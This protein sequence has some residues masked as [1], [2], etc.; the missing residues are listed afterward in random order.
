MDCPNCQEPL[1]PEA[2]FCP[3]CGH[4]A[5]GRAP[6]AD[7]TAVL[8]TVGAGEAEATGAAADREGSDASGPTGELRTCPACGADNSAGRVLCARCGVDLDSGERPVA[9]PVVHRPG[10]AED[11]TGEVSA[12]EGPGGNR[13]ALIVAA[14]VVV[15]AAVGVLVGLWLA[16]SG[17]QDGQSGAPAFDSGVYNE[18]PQALTV[19]GVG[20]SSERPPSGE[21]NYGASNL[22]D[23]DITTAWSHDPAVESAQDVDIA[24]VL[25]EPAWVTALTF[26]NGAQSDDLAFGADGRILR[27]TLLAGG[28]AAAELHLLD[29]PG[30]QRVTL[31]EPILEDTIRLVVLEAVPGDTYD[32]VSLSEIVVIGHPAKGEDLQR[33]VADVQASAE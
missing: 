25:A 10:P 12:P 8:A 32:E 19:T 1:A 4:A 26:A 24:L 18:E 29:Q 27:F 28:D 21:A 3:S 14:I 13:T 20:A 33:M 6:D 9:A 22:V 2:R 31:P 30:L 15:G 23:N 7:G 5:T 16:G 17:G 11:V